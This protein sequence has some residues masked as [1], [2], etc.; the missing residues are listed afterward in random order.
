MFQDGIHGLPIEQALQNAEGVDRKKLSIA[1]FRKLCTEY[2]LRQVDNQRAEF[3][4]L[5]LL[6]HGI[7]HT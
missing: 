2:A 4:R 5:G 7:I 6:V 1:E 3:K